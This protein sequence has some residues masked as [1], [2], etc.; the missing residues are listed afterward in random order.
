MDGDTCWHAEGK[1]NG[2]TGA[3]VRETTAKRVSYLELMS[4]R[5]LGAGDEDGVA[6]RHERPMMSW[7][8]ARDG[9]APLHGQGTAADRL[10]FH[11]AS[12]STLSL[13]S[14]VARRRPDGSRSLMLCVY[15][16]L[17]PAVFRPLSSSKKKNTQTESAKPR[18]R[19]AHVVP[20]LK[21]PHSTAFSWSPMLP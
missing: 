16:V 19:R 6:L 17:F 1:E 21:H 3:S 7:R 9:R 2:Y 18:L 13:C 15:A 12:R 5:W 8:G 10:R 20:S 11:L 4:T 14:A